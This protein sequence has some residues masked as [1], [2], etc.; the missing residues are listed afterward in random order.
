M[1]S[2]QDNLSPELQFDLDKFALELHPFELSMRAPAAVART[3]KTDSLNREGMVVAL[4]GARASGDQ[5]IAVVGYGEASPLPGLHA[6]SVDQI[7]S[8]LKAIAQAMQ[9]HQR[10]LPARAA[11]LDGSLGVF[12]RR[13]RA[14]FVTA[15]SPSPLALQTPGAWIDALCIDAALVPEQVSPCARAALEMAALD[16]IAKASSVTI[17]ALLVA[18]GA[19]SVQR[20]HVLLNTLVPREVTELAQQDETAPT[21]GPGRPVNTVGNGG[22]SMWKVKVGGST[23]P[24]CARKFPSP[25]CIVTLTLRGDSCRFGRADARRVATIACA[26]ERVGAR[27]R[28]DANQAWSEAE[29]AE[30]ADEISRTPWTGA[31]SLAAR[32]EYVK[33]P[34]C[35]EAAT[36][37]ALGTFAERAQIP[38][39]LDETLFDDGHSADLFGA[40]GA[41]RGA[42]ALVLKPTR[43]GFERS[44]QLAAEAARLGIPCVV[45]AAFESGLALC[46]LAIFASV[47]PSGGTGPAFRA[48][49][50]HHG[51]GTFE[52]LESDILDPAFGALVDHDAAATPIVDVLRCDA[53]LASFRGEGSPP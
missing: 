50:I 7:Q 3:G 53:A 52:W 10:P 14:Q 37:R 4:S 1:L 11:A 21:D 48:E 15:L 28:L 27:L 44:A 36:A 45:S 41:G 24:R 20:S 51:L 13:A 31:S 39:A 17:G 43:I 29:A 19:A 2:A 16:A 32:I 38:Y 23:S 9:T 49:S 46:H 26:A 30:F 33:E 12:H 6:E 5:R 22:G 40:D 25:T 18:H 8:Q 47:L 42:A 34:L 35:S